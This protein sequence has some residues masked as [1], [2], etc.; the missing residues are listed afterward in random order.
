M[1]IKI[2]VVDDEPDMRHIIPQEFRKEIHQKEYEF[3]F[4]GNGIEALDILEKNN[5]FDVILLDINMPELDGLAFLGK[6]NELDLSLPK[7]IIISG[8]RDMKNFRTSM[9]LGAYDFVVKPIDFNDLKETIKKCLDNRSK[10][11][12]VKREIKDAGKLQPI[13]LPTNYPA[14][15]GREEFDLHAQMI[16]AEEVG[17][18]FYDFFFLDKNRLGIVVGDVSGKGVPAAL[19]M[20]LS[21]N[22]LRN[23]A[24]KG[25]P[26]DTCLEILNNEFFKIVANNIPVT[27]FYG[28]LDTRDGSFEYCSGGHL[29]PILVSNG[30][31]VI[32][33]VNEGG[34]PIGAFE[35]PDYKVNRIMLN[36][37]EIIFVYTDGVTEA[38]EKG[39]TGTQEFGK[40]RL[41]NCLQH[42]RKFSMKEVTDRVISEVKNF[43]QG[44]R[45]DDITCLALK[46]LGKSI[47]E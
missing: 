38:G 43:S 23:T 44:K 39:N 2:L 13:I 25:M 24:L 42:V 14:F 1:V 22:I 8:H 3:Q 35:N 18:D 16:P 32:L 45:W 28:I 41:M 19:F 6:L 11:N 17:G 30:G 20:P 27:I 4:A 46:Y 26:T 36:R 12:S 40:E 47:K 37:G 29:P 21:M 9:N 34:F 10:I 7:T 33:L 5:T 15:P 31:S